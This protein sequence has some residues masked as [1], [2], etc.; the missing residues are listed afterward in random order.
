MEQAD[1]LTKTPEPP[2]LSAMVAALLECSMLAVFAYHRSVVGLL[3]ALAYA[4]FS[5]TWSLL[6]QR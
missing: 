2:K 6:F 1:D 5:A 3:L 4:W